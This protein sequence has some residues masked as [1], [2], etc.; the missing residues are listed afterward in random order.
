M[1]V[2][3]NTFYIDYYRGGVR[4]AYW[5]S[6]RKHVTSMSSNQAK[7]KPNYEGGSISEVQIL[8]RDT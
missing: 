6:E 8:C 4:V 5:R 3:F 7:S 1:D 2:R